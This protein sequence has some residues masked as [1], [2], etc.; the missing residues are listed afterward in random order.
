MTFWEFTDVNAEPVLVM[1]PT[2]EFY[3]PLGDNIYY[4]EAWCY[5]SKDYVAINTFKITVKNTEPV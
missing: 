5:D 4:L 1:E 2:H 3:D